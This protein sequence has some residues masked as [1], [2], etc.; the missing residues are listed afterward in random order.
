MRSL[1]GAVYTTPRLPT[2]PL[3]LNGM[4]FSRYQ[5]GLTL[6]RTEWVAIKPTDGVGISQAFYIHSYRA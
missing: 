3:L 1:N 4:Y 6:V 2:I 5:M